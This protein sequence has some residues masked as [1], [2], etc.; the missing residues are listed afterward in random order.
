[1]DLPIIPC[2]SEIKFPMVLIPVFKNALEAI[3]FRLEVID[4][5]PDSN[6]GFALYKISRFFDRIR[7]LHLIFTGN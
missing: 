3:E 6:K 5:N 4:D 7:K 2:L 1:M